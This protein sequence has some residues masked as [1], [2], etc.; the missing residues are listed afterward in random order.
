M[1]LPLVYLRPPLQVPRGCSTELTHVGTQFLVRLFDAHDK[2]RDG[3]LNPSEQEE[4]FFAAPSL[5]WDPSSTLG[6]HTNDKGWLSA[7]GFLAQW[8]LLTLTRV[9]AAL[10]YFAHL[11]FHVVEDAESTLPAV[12][13]TRDKRL[14]PSPPRAAHLQQLDRRLLAV[15]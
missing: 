13:V 2:D 8:T 14:D 7:K 6:V 4:L 5:P 10:E 11:G 9:E 1:E 15:L 12:A 3:F